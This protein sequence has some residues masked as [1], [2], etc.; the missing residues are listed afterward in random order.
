MEAMTSSLGDILEKRY[1]AKLGPLDVKNINIMSYDVSKALNYLHNEVLLLH[2][3]I[4]SFNILVKGDFILCKLCDF[5]VSI[6][7]KKDGLLDFDKVPNA[8]YVGTDIYS[9][10]EV[11]EEEP[12]LISTKSE[13]FS[14]GLVLYE[15]ISL[16]PPHTLEMM[17]KKA[18]DFDVE[19]GG[20][21]DELNN[22]ENNLDDDDYDEDD[23]PL[24]GIRPLFPH[25]MKLTKE[26]DD[27][28]HVFYMCTEDDPEKRPDASKLESIFKELNVIVID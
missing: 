25:D 23:E 12:A 1:E 17:T 20:N 5:G 26:Y 27:I 21:A 19:E 3:D 7:V 28:M 8:H 14:F 18:I 10:P 9:A 2:G 11:F 13:I 16:C 15:T 24:Y 6:P 4:K 22:K